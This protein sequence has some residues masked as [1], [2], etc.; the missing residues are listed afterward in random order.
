MAGRLR[1]SEPERISQCQSCIKVD[2]GEFLRAHPDKNVNVSCGFVVAAVTM[3]LTRVCAPGVERSREGRDF[4]PV[5]PDDCPY[6]SLSREGCCAISETE[7][8][9]QEDFSLPSDGEEDTC[10][11]IQC[12]PSIPP[13][14][15][16]LEDKDSFARVFLSGFLNESYDGG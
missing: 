15:I 9:V 8:A 4:C 6:D 12:K 14:E 7:S 3:T 11:R 13:G 10:D 2:S 16:N 1:D 5:Y